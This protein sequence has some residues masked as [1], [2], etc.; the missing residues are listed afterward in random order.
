MYYPPYP[1]PIHQSQ[2][3]KPMTMADYYNSQPSAPIEHKPKQPKPANN[4]P[5]R[6]HFSLSVADLTSIKLKPVA[7]KKPIERVKPSLEQVID[8][9]RKIIKT[10]KDFDKDDSDDESEYD[11]EE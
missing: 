6:P 9:R 11:S 10:D 7:D 3:S 1:Q 5:S 4:K 8:A 2:P